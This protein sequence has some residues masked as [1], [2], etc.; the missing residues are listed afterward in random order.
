MLL[1]LCL[2][3]TVAAQKGNALN[4]TTPQL[5]YA[6]LTG[7][8]SFTAITHNDSL[9][10]IKDGNIQ[11]PADTV[12]WLKITVTNP[13][14]I[15]GR[16]NM[17]V[18]PAVLN[19]IYYFDASSQQWAN[20]SAGATISP[21]SVRQQIG[22]L[23]F[24]LSQQPVNML[25]VKMNFSALKNTTR[26]VKPIIDVEANAATEDRQDNLV[27][28]WLVALS[29]LF[30]FFF[31]NLYLYTSLRDASVKYYLIAQA[32]AMIYITAFRAFFNVFF[33]GKIYTVTIW[34][35]GSVRFYNLDNAMQHAGIVLIIYGLVQLTRS[36]LNTHKHFP[37]ADRLL[38]YGMLSYLLVSFVLVVINSF[39]FHVEAYSIAYDNLYLLMLILFMLYVC[40]AAY[41]RR[42]RAAGPFLLA[43]VLPL[44]FIASVTLYNM[45][46]SGFSRDNVWLPTLAIVSQAF[47]F[48][49]AL[50]ARTKL[51]QKELTEKQMEAQLL[52][53]EVQKININIQ[54]E[55][56]RAEL[57]QERLEANQRELASTTLYMLQKNELLAALKSQ[58][59]ELNKL[60]PKHAYGKLS[61]MESI[62][63][64]NLHLDDDWR[65]FKL[66]FEQLHPHFFENLTVKYPTLTN[67]EIRLCAYFHINLS[68]KEIAALLNIEADSVRRAKSRLMKKMGLADNMD[69]T[70][71]TGKDDQT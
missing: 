2:R 7:N 6:V 49:V 59:E 4:K 16:F 58:I 47:C 43:N 3:F 9:P 24:I 12:C 68:P 54:V 67:N 50:V 63:K 65:K 53:F 46:F 30:F 14:H 29:V 52:S 69:A 17:F 61:G 22:A 51:V 35:N 10:F 15:S 48:S 20:S 11:L 44:A 70:N 19:T 34:H 1:F 39:F 40:I 64:S 31:Y 28:G 26:T 38:K 18:E 36:Y 57:L 66:H 42:V 56:A 55:K 5:Q 23:P 33:H 25:Y 27:Y 21:N 13:G 32:G 71:E 41:R 8:Y 60:Y 62:L 37:V 45:M